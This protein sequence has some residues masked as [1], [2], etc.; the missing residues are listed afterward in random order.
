M[1]DD[2]F[3]T[4]V[5]T[6]F[7]AMVTPQVEERQ[8]QGLIPRPLALVKAQVLFFLD[9]HTEVRLNDEVAAKFSAKVSLSHKEGMPVTIDDLDEI[10][11]FELSDAERHVGHMTAARYRSGWFMAFNFD[12]KVEIII[13]RL[14]MAKQFLQAAKYLFRV[15]LFNAC[16]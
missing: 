10:V 4:N 8:S 13:E 16:N 6:Q 2:E 12:Y 11:D 15:R 1:P 3:A 7:W 9:G 5:F 14:K